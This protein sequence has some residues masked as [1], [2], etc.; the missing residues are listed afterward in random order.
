MQYITIVGNKQNVE[1][2]VT[3]KTNNKHIVTLTITVHNLGDQ[4]QR[5]ITIATNK[6]TLGMYT[7][8]VDPHHRELL[9]TTT[10]QRLA[11]GATSVPA[12]G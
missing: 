11:I 2:V 12:K 9:K 4:Q 10:G 8:I 1:N 6:H 7:H 3:N 5:C